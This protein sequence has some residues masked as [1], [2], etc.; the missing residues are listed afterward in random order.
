MMIVKGDIPSSV[1]YEDDEFLCFMDINPVSAGHCLVIPKA[2]SSDFG[3][4]S[5]LD[6]S[7]L[8]SLV[9][10]IAPAIAAGVGTSSYN[11]ISN[12]GA[13]SGQEVFH[14]HFHITPRK[15]KTKTPW[16]Q[17]PY[18]NKEE[19]QKVLEAIKMSISRS[20]SCL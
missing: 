6:A 16:K 15:E 1:V 19:Q 10:K 17:V 9:H 5:P 11:I 2:H 8:M 7:M 12:I 13:E 14:T 3:K 20:F 18:I 4:M